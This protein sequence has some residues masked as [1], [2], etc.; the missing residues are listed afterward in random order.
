[1]TQLLVRCRL[2]FIF[3]ISLKYRGREIQTNGWSR[4]DDG[5]FLLWQKLCFPSPF[6]Q[7]RLRHAGRH[8]MVQCQGSANAECCINATEDR[9]SFSLLNRVV[10]VKI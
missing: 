8:T 9:G 4:T 10:D 3:W 5:S 2:L 7:K 6:V 1:M